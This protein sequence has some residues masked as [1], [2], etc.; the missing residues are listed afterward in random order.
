M[1][2]SIN[3]AHGRVGIEQINCSCEASG[4]KKIVCVQTHNV[5][6]SRNRKPVVKRC[7]VALV[8]LVGDNADVSE[9]SRQMLSYIER[10]I[11][12]RVVDDDDLR[13]TIYLVNRAGD[14]RW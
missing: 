6:A 5:I 12:G 2:S 8:V 9:L 14:A 3:E 10:R 1:R 13:F 7:D 4:C 11:G